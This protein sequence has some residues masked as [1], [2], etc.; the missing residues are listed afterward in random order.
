MEYLVYANYNKNTAQER[1]TR[2]NK[3]VTD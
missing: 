1:I 3:V 2:L